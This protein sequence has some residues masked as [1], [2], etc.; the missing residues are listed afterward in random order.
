LLR[1]ARNDS[2]WSS[3]REPVVSHVW[4]APLAQEGKI[5]DAA[6][7]RVRSCVRPVDA[8][9]MAAGPDEVRGSG[10]NQF[11][12]HEALET[13]R[14][15]PIPGSTG[16]SSLLT[17]LAFPSAGVLTRAEGNPCYTAGAV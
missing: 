7:G 1:F 10:P 8:A 14:A 9:P 15:Y 2:P 13:L 6:F 3:L 5:G 12:A 4:T 17:T 16:S 11:V